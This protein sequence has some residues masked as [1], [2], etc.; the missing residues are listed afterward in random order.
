MDE[1]LF[2]STR[3]T[4]LAQ[5]AR[6]L[7]VLLLEGQT[8]RKRIAGKPI[9]TDELTD[10]AAAVP[11]RPRYHEIRARF[12]P[13]PPQQNLWDDSGSGSRPKL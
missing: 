5:E 8:L 10:S 7:R 11:P 2:P 1:L 6:R 4:V 12:M 9:K 13:W 3:G